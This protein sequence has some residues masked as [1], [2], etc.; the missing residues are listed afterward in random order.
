MVVAVDDD[1]EEEEEERLFVLLPP[2]VKE[3]ISS[4]KCSMNWEIATKSEGEEKGV[5]FIWIIG[6]G[7]V[8]LAV[9]IFVDVLVL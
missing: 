1:E 7:L 6:G 2:F 3:L 9:V 4:G 5:N 8:L